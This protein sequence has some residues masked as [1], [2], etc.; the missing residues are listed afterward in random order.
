MRPQTARLRVPRQLWP[1]LPHTEGRRT[2]RLLC[3]VPV[4]VFAKRMFLSRPLHFTA[5]ILVSPSDLRA[6]PPP[7]G[8]AIWPPDSDICK[9]LPQKLSLAK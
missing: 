6:R 8:L 3:T 5:V 4:L 2:C 9:L 1:S 7:P